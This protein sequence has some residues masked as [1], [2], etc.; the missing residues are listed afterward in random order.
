MP[1]TMDDV[2]AVLTAEEVDYTSAAGL[3]PEA[4]PYL[5]ELVRSADP[6]LASKATYLASLIRDGRSVQII[7]LAAQRPEPAI[8]V[9]AAAGLTNLQE[10]EA[11]PLMGLLIEDGDVGVRKVA[12]KS[13]AAFASPAMDERMQRVAARDPEPALRELA[14]RS[15]QR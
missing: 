4:L 3:G 2:R 15:L 8:R 1:V 7:E 13:A 14:T 11:S 5:E 12:L 6:L 10:Q 9:A